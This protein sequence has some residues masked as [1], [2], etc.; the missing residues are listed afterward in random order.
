MLIQRSV[1]PPASPS[2]STNHLDSLTLHGWTLILPAGWAMPFFSSLTYTGTRVSG[3]RERAAQYFEASR[4]SFP[5]DYP[6]TEAYNDYAEGREDEERERWER[7]PP[8]K[9]VNYAKLGIRSPFR[10]DWGVVLGLESSKKTQGEGEGM[11]ESE[12]L[13]PAQRE[14]HDPNIIIEPHPNESDLAHVTRAFARDARESNQPRSWLL[15]GPAVPAALEAASSMFIRS[16]G[17][18]QH[19]NALRAKRHLGPLDPNMKAEDIWKV[20]LIMVKLRMCGRGKPEDMGVIYKLTDDEWKNAINM[21]QQRKRGIP[22]LDEDDE[23]GKAS[24]IHCS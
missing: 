6:A 1:E 11:D 15:Q 2:T 10:P 19:L 7:K 24:D 23:E 17:L 13:I 16:S 3:Q 9:R 12:D 5:R 20:G 4:P 22:I 8:A 21:E 14:E 18:L